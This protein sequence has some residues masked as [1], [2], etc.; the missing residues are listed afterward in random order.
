MPG[1]VSIWDYASTEPGVPLA[2]NS[3]TFWYNFRQYL[4]LRERV[5]EDLFVYG[6]HTFLKPFGSATGWRNLL[7]HLVSKK[8]DTKVVDEEGVGKGLSIVLRCCAASKE[9]ITHTLQCNGSET[10]QSCNSWSLQRESPTVQMR[11]SS[12]HF[13]ARQR[14]TTM[15]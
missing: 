6:G 3:M 5:K 8:A 15:P 1:G 2:L 9:W 12:H 4:F 10:I 11:F 14:A 7:R 13:L